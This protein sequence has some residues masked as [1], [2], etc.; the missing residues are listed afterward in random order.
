LNLKVE[1]ISKKAI[2]N[3]ETPG[4]IS[5]ISGEDIKK[6]GAKDLLEILMIHAP[7]FEFGV[8]VEGVVGI[9]MRG[10]W[11]HEGKILLLIDGLE[12]N[13]DVFSNTLFGNHYLPENIKRIEIVRGPG[14]AIYGGYASVGVINIITKGAEMQGGYAGFL[15]SQMSETYSHRNMNFGFGK[16]KNELGLSMSGVY[17]QGIRSQNNNID[18]YLQSKPMKDNSRIET[19]NLNADINYKGLDFRF[20]SDLY[21]F[22]QIDL[23]GENYSGGIL[24]EKFNNIQG[25][26]KYDIKISDKLKI[27]PLLQ[28]K[29]Q[30][31]WNI[32]VPEE[33]YACTKKVN[34]Y[35]YSIT[36]IWDIKANMNMVSGIEYYQTRLSLSDSHPTY[37]ETF[38]D[39]SLTTSYSNF[40]IFGQYIYFNRLANLTL[41]LRY[42]KSSEYGNSFVP[43]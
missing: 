32:D 41:G 9:G 23:W 31:P 39:S 15:Y 8:D 34:K 17:S 29:Y 6:S 7:G 30:L 26:L 18:Y 14:S 42:D 11:A 16:K 22:N 33:E 40:S 37:E 13:E 19:L 27:T 36:S 21:R 3:R 5:V 38:N 35:T 12:C 2:S 25:S 24:K 43:R 28:Y 1:V 4:V 10:L 20:Y